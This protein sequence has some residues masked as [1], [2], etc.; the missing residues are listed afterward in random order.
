MDNKAKL[1][2]HLDNRLP[3]DL[4]FT[5]AMRITSIQTDHYNNLNNREIFYEK[6]V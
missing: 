2:S 1:P 3:F 4:P 5:V 6:Q